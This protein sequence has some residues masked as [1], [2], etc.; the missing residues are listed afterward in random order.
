MTKNTENSKDALQ[1][2]YIR[3]SCTSLK[4]SNTNKID[5]LHT[6]IDEYKRVLELFID[7]LWELGENS[8]IPRL[9]PKEI[10]SSVGTWMTARAVQACAKQSSG[11]VR[12]TRTKQKRRLAQIKKFN[13]QKM[14]KKARK[15]QKIHDETK[16][17][18]PKINEVC[19][20]LDSRFVKLDLE[21]ETSFDGWITL[22][23]LGNNFKITL[24][25]KKTKHF[26]KMLKK[27]KIKQGVRISKTSVTFN[28]A[29][30]ITTPKTQGITVGLDK[31]VKNV[32][33]LSDK[34]ESTDDIHGWNL[35][36]IIKK[37]SRQTKGSRAFDKSQKHRKNYIHWCLNQI[38][39]SNIKTLNSE[40]IINM[41][42]GKRTSKYLS[43]WTYTIIDNKLKDLALE[44]GV[45][46]KE[47]SPVYTSQRCSKCGW[48]CKTNRK[49]K[50]FVCKCGFAADA[51][52]NA[53]L[54]I[55]FDL[56]EISKAEQLMHLNRKGFYWNA[57]GKEPIVLSVQ[58]A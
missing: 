25:F 36:K 57:L 12:G 41:R 48:T 8:T 18:K 7:Y 21:N 40:K 4:F 47:L 23:C 5:E 2:E 49:G 14:F 55:S 19:P 50:K 39:F 20:E 9:L 10:T 24:P 32:Y 34:Q 26:T 29:L 37:M 3:S 44:H 27:G 46:V 52:Y 13:E 56:P 6:F 58:A 28:F 31:G 11:I 54:N 33:S 38:D 22:T 35:D 16:N 15:L 17:T 42:K 43:R 53:S 30:L 51:D 1:E 45:H